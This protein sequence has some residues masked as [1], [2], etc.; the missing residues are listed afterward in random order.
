MNA[1]SIS[2]VITIRVLE[3]IQLSHFKIYTLYDTS[4]KG[5]NESCICIYMPPIKSLELNM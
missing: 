2:H 3:K 5:I 4:F 1:A